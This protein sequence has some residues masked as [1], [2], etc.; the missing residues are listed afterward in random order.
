MMVKRRRYYTARQADNQ[1]TLINDDFV[2]QNISLSNDDIQSRRRKP[3]GKTL[4]CFLAPRW[5]LL[6]SIPDYADAVARIFKTQL[7][8]FGDRD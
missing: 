2:C 5:R 1:N 6:T 4:L 7:L 8:Y 3:Y